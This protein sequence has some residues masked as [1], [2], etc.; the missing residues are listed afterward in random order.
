M[1]KRIVLCLFSSLLQPLLY[2]QGNE[3]PFFNPIDSHDILIR[4][5]FQK[6]CRFV[7]DP[8]TSSAR[9]PSNSK[10]GVTFDPR[11]VEAGDL[12][13][14]RHAEKFFEELHPTIKHPYIMVTHGEHLDEM[15]EEY[16][17]Y[18]DDPKVIA[19]FGIHPCPQT[20]PKFHP[21]PIGVVQEPDNYSEREYLNEYFRYLRTHAKK[22]HLVFMNFAFNNAKE[23]RLIVRDLFKNRSYC[24]RGKRVGFHY[25]LAEMAECTFTLSPIGMGPDCYRTWEA[26]YVGSIPIVKTCHLDPFYEGLPVL[27][28]D[29]WNQINEEFLQREYKRIT[30]KKYSME[31]LYMPYWLNQIDAVRNDFLAQKKSR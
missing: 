14:V 12:I 30:S 20:H 6:H 2:A 5:A 28:V 31:R 16:F 3:D 19:W 17:T 26:L 9:W 29:D 13:F 8:R 1:K 27:I 22:K 23:D 24:K 7:Y 15:K 11:E 21:I 25:Y 18:L 10:G 4:W